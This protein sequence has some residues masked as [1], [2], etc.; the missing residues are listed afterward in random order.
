MYQ[1]VTLE[2]DMIQSKLI[3]SIRDVLSETAQELYSTADVIKMEIADV[4]M[5][6]DD[7]FEKIQRNIE[8]GQ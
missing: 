6:M 3:E 1:D 4:L 7:K 8:R 2:V 5:R